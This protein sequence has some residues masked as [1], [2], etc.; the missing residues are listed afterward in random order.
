MAQM[1][2]F[3]TCDKEINHSKLPTVT[4][5]FPTLEDGKLFGGGEITDNGGS[6]ITD[7]GICVAD[8]YNI[9]EPIDLD[10]CYTSINAGSGDE[11]FTVDL[12]SLYNDFDVYYGDQFKIRAYATNKTGTAYGEVISVSLTGFGTPSVFSISQNSAIASVTVNGNFQEC[13]FCW[14]TSSNPSINN[15]SVVA[16]KVNDHYRAYL[17][18]LQPST[19]YYVK[20]YVK[21]NYGI[22]YSSEV[23]F[24][25]SQACPTSVQDYD[26]NTY[27]VVSIGSQC[28]M[29]ENLRTTHLNNGTAITLVQ[30][31]TAW[32]NRTTGAYCYYNKT[33]YGN[34]YNYYAV[35]YGN[36]CPSGWHVPSYDEVFTT[37]Y[38]ALDASNVG[39]KMKVTGTTYWMSPNT[40]ATNSS[41]FS[42]RG[43]GYRPRGY[44]FRDIRKS[45]VFWT[46]TTYSSNSDY[47]Y[48]FMMSYDAGE[49][50][51][52][53]SSSYDYSIDKKSGLSVRCVKNSSKGSNESNV[54]DPVLSAPSKEARP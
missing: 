1:V 13:G 35:A 32:A 45:A 47:A 14:S 19:R 51:R 4:T 44:G 2:L 46:T 17:T 39:G 42:A 53:G 37:L 8:R 26:G 41:G 25:T 23:N 49:L 24:V 15:S 16:S 27:G 22:S 31:S 48:D 43:G 34:L 36:L 38:N 7:K 40:G 29:K 6:N 30:D 12:T 10:H 5:T 33:N 11:A 50:Y 52:Y 18:E 20:A 54:V 21:D 3:S 9:S 28:W